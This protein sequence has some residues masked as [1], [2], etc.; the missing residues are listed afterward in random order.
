[1]TFLG[2]GKTKALFNSGEK[3]ANSIEVL[4]TNVST[5]VS[6]SRQSLRMDVGIGSREHDL[7]G[8]DDIIFRT[9]SR[10]TVRNFS[11]GT[12]SH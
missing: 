6:S 9:S 5:G 12:P 7:L 3:S 1:M 4:T 8:E 2:S 10:L 11:R